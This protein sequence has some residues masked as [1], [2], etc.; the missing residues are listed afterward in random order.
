MALLFRCIP[1]DLRVAIILRYIG[2]DGIV[3]VLR[4]GTSTVIAEDN[5][6]GYLILALTVRTDVG[7]YSDD[8]LLRAR[9]EPAVLSRS[10][11]AE[12][13]AIAPF[14]SE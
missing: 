11:T 6:L 3:F 13:D 8:G 14:P 1:D 7:K 4:P 2:E 12:P 5:A 10:T 9:F